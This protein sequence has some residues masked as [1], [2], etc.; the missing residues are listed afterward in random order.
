M[1]INEAQ[2]DAATLPPYPVPLHLRNAPTNLMKNLEYGKGYKY[3][4]S[5]E[6]HWVNQEYLPPELE[7]KQYYHPTDIGRERILKERL[8]ALWKKRQY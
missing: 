7:N 8:M 3:A 1:A 5:F 2:Q 4:H 6:G